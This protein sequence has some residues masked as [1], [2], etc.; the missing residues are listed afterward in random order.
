MSVSDERENDQTHVVGGVTPRTAEEAPD[1]FTHY[2]V[3]LEGLHVGRRIA[4]GAE[5]ITIGR[6]D[7]CNVVLPDHELSRAHCRLEVREGEVMVTDLNSTNG[8]FVDGKRITGTVK[9]AN[10]GMLRVGR[11]ALR[12]ELRSRQDVAATEEL[13]R[14][15]RSARS[16]V[17]SLLPA[18]LKDGA[19]RTDWLFEP[20]A[21]IGGDALGY[22]AIDANH[23][24]LYLIDVAGHGAGAALHAASVINVLRKQALPGTDMRQPEQV[25]RGLNAMFPMEEHGDL[26]FTAWYGVYLQ[27][28]RR[29][30]YCA[31]GH[32]PG[33]L[34]GPARGEAT[35]LWTRNVMLGAQLDYEYRAASTA[36]VPGSML[37]LFSDGVFEVETADG[38]QRQL[39]DF[40][41]LLLPSP[42]DTVSEPERLVREMRRLSGRVGFEDDLTVL[43]VTFP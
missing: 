19:V 26:F 21:R 6:V 3:V 5:P 39:D 11:Q 38:A 17:E 10:G 16:Y 7:P 32:H 9:I 14:D 28:E 22:H 37:Y 29:L 36:V 8:T 41:P 4:I 2:L 27:D 12:H 42:I 18:R 31:G 34:V 33:Y 25:L 43:V 15:L 30:R 40:L 35:P 1:K 24:A 23:F 13:E 20:S